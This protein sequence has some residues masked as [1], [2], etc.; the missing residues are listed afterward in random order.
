MRATHCRRAGVKEPLTATMIAAAFLLLIVVFNPP[1][2]EEIDNN[3]VSLTAEESELVFESEDELAA[4]E[5]LEL[6][7]LSESELAELTAAEE[8]TELSAK[9]SAELSDAESAELLTVRVDEIENAPPPWLEY[10]IR[11]GDTIG[12]ILPAIYA[13]EEAHNFLVGQKM[14]T[15]RKLRRGDY[16]Q[17]RLDEQGRLAALRYKTSPEYYFVAERDEFGVWRAQE[18]PPNLLTITMA[19]G[20]TIDNSLFAAADKVGFSDGAINLLI[21]ALETHVDF[22]RDTRKNDT[23]RAIYTEITDD[24]GDIIGVGQLLAFEYVSLLKPRA[25]RTIRGAWDTRH[26]G[27][28]SPSGESMQ[29][30][31]LRAPLKFRRISSRFTK[32]R[33]HPVLKRWRPHRGV[34]Y[35][36][37]TGT[38]V[39]ATAD[40]VVTKVGRDRGYGNVVMIKH[41]NIYTTVY[42]HLRRFAKGIRRDRKVE[43]GRVIGYVGQTGLATGPHLHYEFRV[44][45]KH[46]DPLSAA[47]PKVLPPLAGEALEDFQQRTAAIFVQLDAVSLP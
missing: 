30:A 23:F 41:F 46:I 4:L 16:L 32:R 13:D 9:E 12:R 39:R 31:F 25:P 28:Y 7:E 40:G 15:Y 8:L 14:K 22:Y 34:D 35:A 2:H 27:Y 26:R 11:R 17:F 5:E 37:R 1:T 19:V 3:D 43:Q 38:P 24:D 45:G 29:G 6:T 44:R 42:A 47:V 21:E 36:A 18:S 33:F 20:G 10:R